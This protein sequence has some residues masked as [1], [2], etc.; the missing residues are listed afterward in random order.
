M[1]VRQGFRTISGRLGTS[2][3][4]LVSG[5]IQPP[6]SLPYLPRRPPHHLKMPTPTAR[7]LAG[8]VTVHPYFPRSGTFAPEEDRWTQT[9]FL[10]LHPGSQP[11]QLTSDLLTQ[12]AP[13]P[14]EPCPILPEVLSIKAR[15]YMEQGLCF[16][17]SAVALEIPQDPSHQR[18]RLI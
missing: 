16:C 9:P 5:S 8:Y 4:G 15:P 10:S 6:S 1:A 13:I 18:I 12:L 3:E 17:S 2:L 7:R 14:R 11:S